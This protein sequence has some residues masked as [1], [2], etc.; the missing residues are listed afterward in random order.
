M[1]GLEGVLR[2]GEGV[3]KGVEGVLRER[4]G[5]SHRAPWMAWKRQKR[6]KPWI[7]GEPGWFRR[8]AEYR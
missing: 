5:E 8:V 7:M 1:R 3:L 6:K 2:A 4:T